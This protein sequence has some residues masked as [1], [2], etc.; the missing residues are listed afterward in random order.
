MSLGIPSI[1]LEEY[2]LR[3]GPITSGIYPEIQGTY[4]QICKDS[5]QWPIYQIEGTSNY[6]YFITDGSSYA[7]WII[8]E[9]LKIDISDVIPKLFKPVPING[10]CPSAWGS[11]SWFIYRVNI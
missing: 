10:I 9:E 11:Q 4:K 6:L 5:N 3:I 7:F 1:C 8:V 2:D